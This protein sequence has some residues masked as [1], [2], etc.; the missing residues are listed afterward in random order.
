MDLVVTG[1]GE[2]RCIYSDS[3]PLSQLGKL[4][5]NRASHVEPNSVGQWMADLSPVDGPLLGPFESR[6][7]ALAA[8]VDWL[9]LIHI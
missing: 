1:T 8:E 5:I 2:L 4:P 7:D 9:S 3:I 6:T